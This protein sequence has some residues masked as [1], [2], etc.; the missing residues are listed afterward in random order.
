MTSNDASQIDQML[1]G[2]QSLKVTMP[3]SPGKAGKEELD[4]DKL[5]DKVYLELQGKAR[6]PLNPEVIIEISEPLCDVAM[7]TNIR[8]MMIDYGMRKDVMSAN[9]STDD[10]VRLTFSFFVYIRRLVI[11]TMFKSESQRHGLKEANIDTIIMGPTA[12]VHLTL[13]DSRGGALGKH[14]RELYT[15][16]LQELATQGR[17]TLPPLPLGNT[18]ARGGGI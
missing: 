6:D 5:L 12:A 13:M 7:A 14:V 9:L 4:I 16:S 17:S 10:V 3:L 2:A 8:G 15:V 1:S 18:G 11:E